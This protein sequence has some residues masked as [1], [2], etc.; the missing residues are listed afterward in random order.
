MRSSIGFS[1]D[2]CGSARAMLCHVGMHMHIIA[3]MHI[4]NNNQSVP[5]SLWGYQAL[6]VS[7]FLMK[8]IGIAAAADIA[9]GGHDMAPI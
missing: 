8:R 3:G 2:V 4:N 5:Q 6:G 1:L 9:I 7:P